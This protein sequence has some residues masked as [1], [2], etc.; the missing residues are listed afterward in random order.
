MAGP[1]GELALKVTAVGPAL[2]YT[3]GWFG[4]KWSGFHLFMHNGDPEAVALATFYC[5]VTA[6]RWQIWAGV[7][8]LL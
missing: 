7:D 8:T 3:A 4:G 5:A 1:A 2:C 6:E